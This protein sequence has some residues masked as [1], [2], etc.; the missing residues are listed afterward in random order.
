[1][2]FLFFSYLRVENTRLT[3][4]VERIQLENAHLNERN[5][6]LEQTYSNDQQI[7]DELKLKNQSLQTLQ[8]QFD[9]DQ[10]QINNLQEK[11]HLF[12]QEKENIRQENQL[13]QTTIE[14]LNQQKQLLNNQFQKS[15]EKSRSNE[16]QLTVK[17]AEMYVPTF[18]RRFPIKDLRIFMY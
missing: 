16:E 9:N 14:Q 3:D 18:I 11:C 13:L 17:T 2:S 1:M 8:D 12:E 15:E 6:T 5:S 4:D 10:Q 7:I